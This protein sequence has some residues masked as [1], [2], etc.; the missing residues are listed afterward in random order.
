MVDQLKDSYLVQHFGG[1]VAA[2]EGGDDCAL[3]S[4]ID[5]NP[6]QVWHP[7]PILTSL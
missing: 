7:D 2:V 3:A 6:V 5:G 1:A 4:E